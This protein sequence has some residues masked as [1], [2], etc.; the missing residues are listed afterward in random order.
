MSTRRAQQKV[1]LSSS[2]D[3]HRKIQAR[4]RALQKRASSIGNFVFLHS[5]EIRFSSNEDSLNED[6]SRSSFGTKAAIDEIQTTYDRIIEDFNEQ[7]QQL[8]RRVQH[9]KKNIQ[10]SSRRAFHS[11]QIFFWN[12]LDRRIN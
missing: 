7:R 8:L 2:I 5:F 6:L 9:L 4:I 3:E 12:I 11:T 1:N 10:Q